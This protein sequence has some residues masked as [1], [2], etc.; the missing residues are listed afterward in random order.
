MAGKML[1]LHYKEINKF[2]WAY[3]KCYYDVLWGTQSLQN[4]KSPESWVLLH[5]NLISVWVLLGLWIVVQM[6]KILPQ[7]FIGTQKR[8]T[9]NGA[10]R[11]HQEWGKR[12]SEQEW[13]K[14]TQKW[15]KKIAPA[16]ETL[17]PKRHFQYDLPM[18]ITKNNGGKWIS[19][20]TAR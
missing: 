10:G 15:L 7:G 14:K 11:M 4:S 18:S 3:E 16:A 17:T 19:N 2:I 8:E 9:G 20:F 12:Q 13:L 1:L 6:S 5:Q